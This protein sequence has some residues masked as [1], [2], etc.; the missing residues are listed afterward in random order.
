MI[1]VAWIGLVLIIISWIM[2]IFSLSKGKK[3]LLPSFAGLQATGVA[4]LVI[5]DFLANSAL[6]MPGAL[7][8]LSCLGAL[9][10]LIMIERR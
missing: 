9:I 8:V 3:Q 4:L 2:Q 10:A 6:S 5:S 7:N 1:E